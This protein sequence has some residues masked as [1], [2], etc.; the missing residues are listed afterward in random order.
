MANSEIE[1]N[2]LRELR[3]ALGS[4]RVIGIIFLVFPSRQ[5][6]I[7]K[8]LYLLFGCRRP[9]A[10]S[11]VCD[12]PP[13]PRLLG[14][15]E[16]QTSMCPNLLCSRLSPY[17]WYCVTFSHQQQ[18]AYPS[19][20]PQLDQS[21]A[22]SNHSTIQPFDQETTPFLAARASCGHR[23]QRSSSSSAQPVTWKYP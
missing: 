8:I 7:A 22:E 3:F 5:E 14:R 18:I 12:R 23:P 20:L 11:Y 9:T 2:R 15:K 1:T 17:C 19:P 6:G 21:A 13:A 16:L 10:L 4:A